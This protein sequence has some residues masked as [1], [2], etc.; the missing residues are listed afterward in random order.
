[1]AT[2]SRR[3][4]AVKAAPEP[5][6]DDLE[7]DDVEEV[8][9]VEEAP[10]PAR[11]NKAAAKNKAKPAAVVVEEDDDDDEDE[12]PKPA[13]SKKSSKAA[14]VE[15]E[16]LDDED[17][18]DDDLPEVKP[19]ARKKARKSPNGIDEAKPKRKAAPAESD[20][21]GTA[22]LAEHIE[23]QTGKV[24]SS[25]DLRT[26]LR[27]MARNGSIEREVG[28]ER[29]RYTFDGPKDAV[30]RAVIKAVKAGE[31]DAAKKESLDKLKENVASG[32]TTPKKAKATKKKAAPVEDDDFED[33]DED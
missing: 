10:K 16:E 1:M 14:K 31:I 18:D 9:D 15:V 3:A 11:R 27:K 8:E 6:I 32:K 17:D 7:V 20:A 30:V 28:V 29:S 4:A 23:E 2:R 26:L 13:R 19:A 12:A 21:M 5:D 24:Y 25:Y 22:W 33:D